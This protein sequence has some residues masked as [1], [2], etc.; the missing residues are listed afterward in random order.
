MQI[1]F[2]YYAA[3]CACILAG[4][5]P[6]ESLE[7]CTADQYTDCCTKTALKKMKAPLSAATTQ[8]QMEMMDARPDLLTLQ[9]IT[10]IWAS[11]HFLP[12]DLTARKPHCSRSYLNKYRLICQPNSALLK[13]TLE[14]AKKL[15]TLQAAG[16][17]MHILSDTWAH[18]NFAGTPSMVI[19]N[20]TSE[21]YELRTVD[22]KE[23]SRKVEFRHKVGGEDDL[24]AGKYT[25]TL[26]QFNEW[27]V[28]NLGHGRVGHLPDYSFMRYR[29]LPA[30]GD[31]RE[32]IKDNPKEY[33]YAFAQMVYALKWLKSGEGEFRLDTYDWEAIAPL[34]GQIEAILSKRQLLASADWK[35]LG[36]AL[37]GEPI[38]EFRETD[39]EEAFLAAPKEEQD[40]TAPGKFIY[41]A[42]AQKSMVTNRIFASGSLL[43]GLSVDYL[44]SGFRGQKDFKKLVEKMKEGMRP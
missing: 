32:V 12:G 24:E 28:M 15:G 7:I 5:R 43:A 44:K 30:W 18:R 22:G 42:L 6:A 26:M 17:A 38:P 19:N 10:R 21:F 41:A 16:L 31:Y 13:E 8:T 25:N 35:A 36:E 33:L 37:S 34:R 1:D 40:K 39:Y 27:S 2:H 3:Y 23:V 11:F 4:F 29:Y 20:I 14:Q 9:D